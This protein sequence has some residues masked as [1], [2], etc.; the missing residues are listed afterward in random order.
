MQ[1]WIS[2]WKKCASLAVV[3]VLVSTSAVTLN[4]GRF[5]VS[6]PEEEAR[7]VSEIRASHFLTQATFGPTIEEIRKLGAE[8]REQGFDTAI[9]AWIDKQLA[10]PPTHQV[11]TLIDLL[12][13]NGYEGFAT[14]EPED[15]DT[16]LRVDA[17]WHNA[18]SADDQLRQRLAWALSQ[19][20][21]VN[22]S[23]PYSNTE[24]EPSG[25]PRVAGYSQYY[26]IFVDGVTGNYRDILGQVSYHPVMGAFLTH[27]NN[28]KANPANGTYPD[29]NYARECMQLFTIGL[30]KVAG[31]N[32]EFATDSNGQ[33]I[34]T[35]S[36]TDIDTMA[37]VFTG[38]SFDSGAFG[39]RVNVT[40]PMVPF[41]SQHDRDPK[42]LLDGTVLR[43]GRSARDDIDNALDM[44]FNQPETPPFVARRL[45]QLFNHSNP[46]PKYIEQIARRFQ[47]TRRQPR[48]DMKAI[49]KALLMSNEARGLRIRRIRDEQQN[50]IAVEASS[51]RENYT[52]L[53]EPVIRVTS[54]VRA[55]DG[56]SADR[57]HFQLGDMRAALNQTPFRSP[58]VFNF[59]SPDHQPAGPLTGTDLVAPEFEIL[60]SVSV[61]KIYN[62]FRDAVRARRL[63]RPAFQ[64]RTKDVILPGIR[65]L[66]D[67]AGDAN[68][69]TV[70]ENQGMKDLLEHLD[71][72]LCQGTM[73]ET[74]KEIIHSSVK[75]YI[76]SQSRRSDKQIAV[77][78]AL[79]LVLT[80]PDCAIVD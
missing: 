55:F 38:L 52:S 51:R 79:T 13:A 71:L 35:Y 23:I 66:Y 8:I 14:R 10:L 25:L 24:I 44:L 76:N 64:G 40:E 73:S 37:R 72:L 33:L 53:R 3:C 20:F 60:T 22:D 34:P 41:N 19:I 69:H 77:Q 78:T 21:V 15:V 5:E 4:A 11:D 18:I 9:E 2:F 70:F 75:R 57:K 29:E 65:D 48:G 7:I 80:S 62:L 36:N 39:G 1:I 61:N 49:V 45:I 59:Y 42:V 31:L 16:R 58:S 67:L 46:T 6:S 26:D 32:G 17:W 27:L 63:E 68:D 47:G 54:L 43:A 12:N 30:Y 56:Y 74:T 50:V 28:R